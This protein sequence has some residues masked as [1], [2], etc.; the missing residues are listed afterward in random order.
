VP[1]EVEPGSLEANLD[2]YAPR[3]AHGSS[4]SPAIHAGLFAR[5]GNLEEAVRLLRIAARIDLDDVTGTTAGGLHLA[6]FGGVW[7]A[8]V[9]GF[10]GV[11]PLPHA[12]HLDPRVPAQWGG[13]TIHLQYRGSRLRVRAEE[14]RC[15]VHPDA[16]MLVEFPGLPVLA[17]EGPTVFERTPQGWRRQERAG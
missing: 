15:E 2:Y 9:Y 11:R 12:L 5:A 7:Q 16:P 4:L 6:T 1:D 17:I 14:S 13:L 3:C 8:L 10:A